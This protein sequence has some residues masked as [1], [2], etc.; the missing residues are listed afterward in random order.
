[1]SGYTNIALCHLVVIGGIPH[2]HRVPARHGVLVTGSDAFRDQS[3]WQKYE[4]EGREKRE[5][6]RE[7]QIH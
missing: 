6:K 1:V 5:S 7:T 4:G 3:R 2:A